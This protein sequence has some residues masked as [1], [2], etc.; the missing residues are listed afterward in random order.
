MGMEDDWRR[1]VE[2]EKR[3]ERMNKLEVEC[4]RF[5]KAL[6]DIQRIA[7][8]NSR[9]ILDIAQI[10]EKALDEKETL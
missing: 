10:A 1:Q 6:E 3:V 5:R 7:R 8:T 4:A 9:Q 2:H